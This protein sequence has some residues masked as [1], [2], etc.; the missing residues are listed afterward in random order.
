MAQTEEENNII[1]MIIVDIEVY[2]NNQNHQYL[3]IQYLVGF[4]ILY[5][6]W[7]VKN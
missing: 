1:D 6:S 7:V 2:L 4:K 5:K 3:T